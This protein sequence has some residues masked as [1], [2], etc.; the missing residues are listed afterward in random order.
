VR[1]SARGVTAREQGDLRFVQ[2][3]WNHRFDGGVEPLMRGDN[4]VAILVAVAVL[5][6]CQGQRLTLG[7][8]RHTLR[9]LIRH[10]PTGLVLFAGQVTD[11]TN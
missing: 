9:Y 1:L 2:R 6:G 3:S 10:R 4:G 5:A 7:R 8:P 11:P